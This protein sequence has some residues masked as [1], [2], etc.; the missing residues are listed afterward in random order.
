MS[1]QHYIKCEMCD[2]KHEIVFLYKA[3]VWRELPSEWLTLFSGDSNPDGWHFCSEKCLV[4]W[5]SGSVVQEQSNKPPCKT[6]RFVLVDS[7]KGENVDCIMWADGRIELDGGSE[8]CGLRYHCNGYWA[9]L[10]DFAEHH[11]EYPIT[12]IDEEQA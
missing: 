11:S 9:S 7:N 6:R 12:W 1:I 2:T 5:V 3:A 8:H 10:E 4:Q